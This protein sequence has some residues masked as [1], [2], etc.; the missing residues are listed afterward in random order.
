MVAQ[1]A[2]EAGAVMEITGKVPGEEFNVTWSV[3]G[4][5]FAV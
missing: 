3:A 1:V 4:Q 5:A 2:E